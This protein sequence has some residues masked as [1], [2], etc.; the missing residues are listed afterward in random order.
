VTETVEQPKNEE[1]PV[2]QEIQ[3]ESTE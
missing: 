1:T 3:K 2:K